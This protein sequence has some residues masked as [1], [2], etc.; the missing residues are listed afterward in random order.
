M[1]KLFFLLIGVL[2]VFTTSCAMGEDGD[3]YLAYSWTSLPLSWYD[4][5]PSIPSTIYNGTY[6]ATNEGRFYMEYTAWDNSS[7]WMYYTISANPAQFFADGEPAYFEIALYSFGPSL[8]KWNYA[9]GVEPKSDSVELHSEDTSQFVV[10]TQGGAFRKTFL[11][12]GF[13]TMTVGDTT[14]ELEFGLLEPVMD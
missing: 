2:I 13:E 9:R 12:H 6:Y 7:W 8:Y 3:T 5:N 1:K 4:E 14:I 11:H 10:K